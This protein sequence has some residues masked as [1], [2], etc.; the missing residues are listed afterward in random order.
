MVFWIVADP[1]EFDSAVFLAPLVLFSILVFVSHYKF[2]L[3]QNLGWEVPGLGW[4]YLSGLSIGGVG[5]LRFFL[6]LI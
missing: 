1:L 5:F 6:G 3:L 2:W 4:L